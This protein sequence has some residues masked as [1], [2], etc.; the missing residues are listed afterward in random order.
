MR[1]WKIL[2]RLVKTQLPG[3]FDLP[4][5]KK[6]K[7]NQLGKSISIILLVAF[8][9]FLSLLSFVYSYGIGRGLKSIGMADMLPELSAAV[10][11]V[12]IFLT[13]VYK[14]RGIVFD[15][16]DFDFLLSLP[17]RLT[18]VVI[19]RLLLLYLIN[20]PAAIIIMIP[21]GVS[22]CMLTGWDVAA[23]LLNITGALL[24]PLL[25]VTLAAVIG[26]LAAFIASRFRK[27]RIINIILIFTAIFGIMAAPYFA[28]VGTLNSIS[29]VYPPAILYREAVWEKQGAAMILFLLLSFGS[30][31]LFAFI[32][33]KKFIALNTA[34]VKKTG[35][36]RY[37]GLKEDTGT[38]FYALY[39]KEVKRY[40]ASVNYVINTGF[41]MVL[42]TVLGIAALFMPPDTLN[43]LLKVPD[44]LE[45]VKRFL[46]EVM[47]FSAAMTCISASSISL[48]GKNLWL[49]KSLPLSAGTIF[50]SKMAVNLVMTVPLVIID[51]LLIGIGF[52]LNL[53]EVISIMIF[54]ISISCYTSVSGLFFN[55]LMPKFD[56]SSEITVIK[57]SLAVLASLFSGIA[58][59]MLPVAVRAALPGITDFAGL[60][61]AAV[62]LSVISLGL[63]LSIMKTGEKRFRAFA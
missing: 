33:G 1:E 11:S 50:R 31:G 55:L 6:S 21:A 32:T 8:A 52:K 9:L 60:L 20:L 42:L 14:I 2:V 61:V 30:F 12:A 53:A 48:E 18:T 57:Q 29:K 3:I 62:I 13:T 25:P 47:A 19:D 22:Y 17:V 39:K 10:A 16:K 43:R 26:A 36:R 38:P 54:V 7:K 58:M 45:Q 40:F 23:F 59:S 5:L 4:F 15:F 51:T 46:P 34:L 35:T 28:G 41:G 63:Y 49:L 44:A 27:S 37:K 24:L 56:W